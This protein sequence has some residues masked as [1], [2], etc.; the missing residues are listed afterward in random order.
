MNP[1]DQKMIDLIDYLIY[2]K[3]HLSERNFCLENDLLQQTYSRI[4]KGENHFTVNQI[5]R[6]GKKYKVNFNWLFGTEE[7]MFI[8]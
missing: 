6:I 2:K 4:K 8:K 7:E 3:I 1:V 5:E